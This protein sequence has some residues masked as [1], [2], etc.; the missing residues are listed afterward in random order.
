MSRMRSSVVLVFLGLF[1]IGC[2]KADPDIKTIEGLQ[3]RNKVLSDQ[4]ADLKEK[5]KILETANPAIK[6]RMEAE[7]KKVREMIEEFGRTDRRPFPKWG[8]VGK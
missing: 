1:I 3:D 4:V 5:V 2:G 7:I 6:E 8:G